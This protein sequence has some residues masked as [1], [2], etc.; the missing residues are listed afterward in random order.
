MGKAIQACAFT[1]A[2]ILRLIRLQSSIWA[3]TC[4]RHRQPGCG[5]NSRLAPGLHVPE[6]TAGVGIRS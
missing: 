5:W 1:K 4:C 2:L 3:K 6:Q